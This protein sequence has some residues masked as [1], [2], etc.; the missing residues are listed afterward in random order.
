MR[1]PT[2]EICVMKNLVTGLVVMIIFF[3]SMASHAQSYSA[4]AAIRH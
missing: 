2:S 1:G 4:R 3:V